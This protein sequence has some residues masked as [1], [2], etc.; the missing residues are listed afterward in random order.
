MTYHLTTNDL[1]FNPVIVAHRH[2]SLA[3]PN[4]NW[5]LSPWLHF[6]V[7]CIDGWFW[8]TSYGLVNS[9]KSRRRQINYINYVTSSNETHVPCE[10]EKSKTELNEEGTRCKQNWTLNQHEL[11]D[12]LTKKRRVNNINWTETH[13]YFPFTWRR[14]KWFFCLRKMSL[15]TSLWPLLFCHFFPTAMQWWNDQSRIDCLWNFLDQITSS[16]LPPFNASFQVHALVI[17]NCEWC[18]TKMETVFAADERAV[19]YCCC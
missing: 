19:F 10:L 7:A 2:W 16:Y 9:K 6:I 5:I 14:R 1:P 18:C 15:K 13:K 12:K 8:L 4:R 17:N 3:R 11:I